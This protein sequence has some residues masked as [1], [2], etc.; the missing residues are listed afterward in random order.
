L[1]CLSLIAYIE[2]L[3][4]GSDS[5]YRGVLFATLAPVGIKAILA[6]IVVV[7]LAP[8]GGGKVIADGAH[9]EIEI[10]VGAVLGA[11]CVAFRCDHV[12]S[13]PGGSDI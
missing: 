13:V 12:I 10:C 3:A 7:I 5:H 4:G 6:V 1:Y 9:V 11:H 8:H 2:S